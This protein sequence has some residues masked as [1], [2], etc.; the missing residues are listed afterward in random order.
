MIQKAIRFWAMKK[1][2][3]RI[4]KNLKQ[5]IKRWL[6]DGMSLGI[7]KNKDITKIDCLRVFLKI[8]SVI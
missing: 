2:I 4:D 7:S 3:L 6:T 8:N 1:K 5:A